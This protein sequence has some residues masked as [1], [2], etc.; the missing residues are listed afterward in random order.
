VKAVVEWIVSRPYRPALVAAACA[1][2]PLLAQFVTIPVLV[3]STA[4]FGLQF[5]LV[6]AAA[7]S[8]VLAG[9]VALTG[10]DV[11]LLAGG[12]AFGMFVGAAVGGVLRWAR[13]LSLAFQSV[14][15]VCLVATAGV[16]LFGPDPDAM[17]GDLLESVAELVAQ[18]ATRPSAILRRGCS[19]S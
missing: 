7:G 19:V 12:G 2:V 10:N 5:G 1:P 4:H 6:T 15:L 16:S 18:D 13:S 9:V 14:V 3:L 17:F 8:L 11:L